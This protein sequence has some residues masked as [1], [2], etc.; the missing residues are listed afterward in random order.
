MRSAGVADEGIPGRAPFDLFLARWNRMARAGARGL[1]E[2]GGDAAAAPRAAAG[3]SDLAP[4]ESERGKPGG[5][6][7][8]DACPAHGSGAAL[9]GV[10][11][12]SM[13]TARL[14]LATRRGSI[15]DVLG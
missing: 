12:R 1:R 10:M 15:L 13:A 14:L 4:G 3:G 8:R 5:L 9:R 2:R 11:L 6:T 7:A